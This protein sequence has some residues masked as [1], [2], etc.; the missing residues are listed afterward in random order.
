M[1]NFIRRYKLTYRRGTTV[2]QK[3]PAEYEELVVDF[4]R[5]VED[6]RQRENYAFVY[7]ADETSVWLDASSGKCIDAKGAKEVL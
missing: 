2:C 7:A 3:T 4:V 1:D 5:Y 6:L